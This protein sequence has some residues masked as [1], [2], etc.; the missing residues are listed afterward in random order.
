MTGCLYLSFDYLFRVFLL[1]LIILQVLLLAD[2]IFY[3]L[4]TGESLHI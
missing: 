1:Y 3:P 4:W 2:S